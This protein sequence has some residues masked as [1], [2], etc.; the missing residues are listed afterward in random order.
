MSVE[1]Y[2]LPVTQLLFLYT[3]ISF[4]ILLP[5]RIVIYFV[6]KRWITKIE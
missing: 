4:N 5:N 1:F 2:G 3:F 6:T